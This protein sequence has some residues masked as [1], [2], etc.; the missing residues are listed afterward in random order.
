MSIMFNGSAQKDSWSGEGSWGQ[1]WLGVGGTCA[2]RSP[3]AGYWCAPGAPRRISVP[4]H[5]SGIVLNKTQP[6]QSAHRSNYPPHL[7]IH[8]MALMGLL[9]RSTDGNVGVREC[10]VGGVTI[11]SRAYTAPYTSCLTFDDA[12]YARRLPNMPYKAVEGA[13]LH[14]WGKGHWYSNIF[15][16]GSQVNETGG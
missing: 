13:V 16:I 14:A 5:P 2:D 6:V 1:H 8:L 3:P 12:K 10:V 4:N 7:L 9:G 15:E 11:S